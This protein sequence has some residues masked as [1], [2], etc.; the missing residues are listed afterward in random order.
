MYQ[1][2]N[3]QKWNNEEKNQHKNIKKHTQMNT[4]YNCLQIN[5]DTSEMEKEE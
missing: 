4:L 5:F 1:I 2:W 3:K